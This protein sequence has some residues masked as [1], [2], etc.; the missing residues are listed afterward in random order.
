MVVDAAAAAVADSS[1]PAAESS[2]LLLDNTTVTRDTDVVLADAV[3][4]ATV[5]RAAVVAGLAPPDLFRR[6]VVVA[7]AF[8]CDAPNVA[9][10][11]T[12]VS[13][14]VCDRLLAR[15]S[16]GLLHNATGVRADVAGRVTDV[17]ASV[18][19]D[20]AGVVGFLPF[21]NIAAVH[22]VTDLV[23][24]AV[25]AAVVVSA[26]TD[27]AGR[28]VADVANVVGRSTSVAAAVAAAVTA[29]LA[30]STATFAAATDA[31]FS[32]KGSAVDV[33]ILPRVGAVGASTT[34][35]RRVATGQVWRAVSLALPG[36]RRT[37]GKRAGSSHDFNTFL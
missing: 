7:A 28:T 11:G 16:P 31:L 34:A 3:G 24:T 27:A 5:G 23:G 20:L 35:A 30:D 26:A 1:L 13:G 33:P 21:D 12:A 19:A 17:T 4:R 2:A 9:R 32:V 37:E 6:P 29:V 36:E 22:T 25:A 10:G 14:A 8:V 15:V 18:G